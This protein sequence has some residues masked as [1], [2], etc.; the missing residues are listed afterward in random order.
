MT[1]YLVCP[2]YVPLESYIL[3]LYKLDYYYY[4]E[5]Y[6]DQHVC[7][8]VCPSVR[9]VIKNHTSFLYM[10]PVAMYVSSSLPVAAPGAKSAVSSF[11]FSA[12]KLFVGRQQVQLAC[13]VYYL[14]RLCERFLLLKDWPNLRH[15][16]L[17]RLPAHRLCWHPQGRQPVAD[18]TTELMIF[19]TLSKS[20][21]YLITHITIKRAIFIFLPSKCKRSTMAVYNS[22]IATI[23]QLP[24]SCTARKFASVI[25]LHRL[26]APT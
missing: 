20:E 13:K 12:L 18:N 19:N 17:C 23:K 9:S 15:V 10:F 4:C 16:Q 3:A 21:C 25:A 8:S 6:C 7:L 22:T 5:K 14:L 26:Q 1:Y 24:P 11:I 2:R